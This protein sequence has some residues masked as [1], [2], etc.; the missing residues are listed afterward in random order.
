MSFITVVYLENVFVIMET[1]PNNS[2]FIRLIVLALTW[3][4]SCGEADNSSGDEFFLSSSS[5]LMKVQKKA[6]TGLNCPKMVPYEVWA[7]YSK[8]EVRSD[9]EAVLEAAVASEI[10]KRAQN[11]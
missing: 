7:I 5:F 10:T 1:N 4:F 3:L 11:I 8:S 9:L 6:K 2:L